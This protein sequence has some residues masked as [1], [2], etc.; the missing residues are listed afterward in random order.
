MEKQKF[1]YVT[2]RDS[3]NK[4]TISSPLE[5][6]KPDTILFS[7]VGIDV[8]FDNPVFAMIELEYTEADQDSSGEAAQETEKKLTYYELDLGL[9]H[10]VRK[11]SEPIS[12][13]ANFLLPVPGG[14]TWPSG[15]LICGENWISYKHQGHVELRAALPRRHDMPADKGLLLITGTV[16][17]QKDLFFFLVQSELG[18]LYKVTLEQDP[19]NPKIVTNIIVALFDTIQPATSLCI[20]RTGLLYTA[21]ELGNNA[22]FQFQGIDDPTAV[23]STCITDESLNEELG[24]D[25]ASASRVAPLFKASSRLQNLLLTDDTSSLS[26]CTDMMLGDLSSEGS[27][28]IYALCGRGIRST[29][30]TLRHGVSM[31]E[32]AV[33]ELPGRPLAVWTVKKEPTDL[34]DRY[35][36]V[37]FSNATLV[38]SIGENVE[39]VTDS[40]FLTSSPSLQVGLLADGALIQVH[41]FGIRHIRADKRT[42]EWKTPGRRSIL[43]ATVNSRQVA[44]ALS[45]GEIIY[46]ELDAAGTLV[47]MGTLDM[48]KEISAMDLGTV[49][50]GRARCMFLAVGCW[51]DS[52]QLLTLDPS[53]VLSKGPAFSVESRPTS[54]CFVEMSNTGAEESAKTGASIDKKGGDS[55]STLYLN[56]GLEKGVLFRVAIDALTGDASYARQRFLG[57]KPVTLCR[58]TVQGQASLMALT[59][60]SFLMYTYQRRH[61]QDPVS[62][63]AL[64]SVADFSSEACPDGIVAV[65]GNTLRVLTIENLGMMFNQTSVPLKYTPRK[66]CVLPGTQQIAIIET[67]HNEYSDAQKADITSRSDEAF[68]AAASSAASGAMEAEDKAEEEGN[69]DVDFTV[70]PL[71]GPVPSEQGHWASCIRIFDVP[72]QATVCL[73]EMARNEAAFSV[74]YCTFRAHSE[75]TFLVVGTAQDFVQTPKSFRGCFITVYR[76]LEGTL[77]LIHQ[78]EVEDIPACMVEFQGKLLV[79]VGK[80]LRLYDMGKRKLL[81][82]CENKSFPTMIVKLQVLG[83]RIY[84]GSLSESAHFVKYNNATSTLSI[85]AD[86]TVPR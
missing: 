27:A 76:L 21:S 62:Y 78:T 16:H 15:V 9:N 20:T 44:V 68:A 2:N 52:V 38:L 86:D 82:K 30:R 32:M 46:F 65:A 59:S 33:S 53:D 28:Q 67:D 39:E 47:E 73:Q 54:L 5:A 64:E 3:S 10:V 74:C 49:P 26:P 41:T 34:Y 60:R 7:V 37:S 61:Y 55:G 13:T 48:G 63:E 12:R 83:D 58:V 22:L 35:I 85:F 6:H 14:E 18:D 17:K 11:W 25:A 71:R 36:V 45:G 19:S 23:R 51:D 57:S 81:K 56:V 29:L 8:G 80:V 4:L 24:D 43:M 31:S 1:V 75:E 40:G 66:M 42:S 50:V 84:V 69:D 70:L 79:G 72:A 77:Q